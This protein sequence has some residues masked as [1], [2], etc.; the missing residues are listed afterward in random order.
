MSCR[1]SSRLESGTNRGLAPWSASG[2]LTRV[3]AVETTPDVYQVHAWIRQIS[4][5]IW[6]RLLVRT[7]STL[8]D[9][10]DVLQIAF[11]WS[12]FHLHRFRAST[13]GTMAS[14]GWEGSASP[15]MHERFSSRTSGSAP[16]SGSSTNMTS[17]TGGSTRSGW[18]G[19][20]SWSRAE[21]T[22]SASVGSG[23]PL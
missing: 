16:T 17:A 6:R 15:T 19:G 13:G 4:P 20:S 21:R 8:A 1:D 22:R 9:L 2:T 7:D 12:D 3:M 11:G 5:M 14:I 10:H 18:S 23:R